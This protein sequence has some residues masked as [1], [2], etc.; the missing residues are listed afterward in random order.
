MVHGPRASP[1]RLRK[2]TPLQDRTPPTELAKCERPG[3]SRCMLCGCLV[4]S[5]RWGTEYDQCHVIIL[6]SSGNESVGGSH[7]ACNDLSRRQIKAAC[8][9]VDQTF[10]TSFFFGSIHGFADTVGEGDED[11]SRYDRETCLL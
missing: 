4:S 2:P 11:V 9:G 5:L 1:N 7:D 3:N 6:L 10:L 8:D